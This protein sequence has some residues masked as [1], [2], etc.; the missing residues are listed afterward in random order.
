VRNAVIIDAVRTPRG[1]AKP[2]GGLSGVTALETVTQLL[3]ALERRTGIDPA[4]VDDVILGCATQTGEQ[5][6]NLAKTA[7]LMAGWDVG[8]PGVTINR[9]CTSGL[10]AIG[11]A[12]A[13]VQA[14][15]ADVVIAG[16]V[17]SVSRVPMYADEGPLYADPAVATATGGGVFMGVAADLVATLEGFERPELDAY[18]VDS[19]HRAARAWT[20]GRFVP[21][22]VLVTDADGGVTL[23]FD[24]H[25][26]PH[27][28][29]EEAAAL[30][31]AFGG[32]GADG[33]DAML[34]ERFPELTEIRHVHHRGNSPSLADG[35]GAVLVTT[36]ARARELG[37]ETRATIRSTATRSVDPY[38][39]LTAGQ[40]AVVEAVRRAGL[41]LAEIELVEFAEAFAALCLK[42]QRDLGIGPDRFNVNGGTIAMGHA[43]GATGAILAATLLDEMERR[44][45]RTGAVGIS[46]AAG[47][48]SAMVLERP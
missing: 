45:V 17:E 26:R 42:F 22:L 6:G 25:V 7:A 5:G 43:F 32:I 9:F 29:I 31:G 34:L 4:V 40:D 41:G 36:E 23:D 30:D 19:H 46:G 11:M 33:Q 3:Q 47:L 39:M 38:L 1:K 15:M 2:G 21:S 20:E 14:G 35:A 10:D 18:G 28:T 48:G 24:E 12:A 37:L 13:K 16:G 8:V 27:S 44:D